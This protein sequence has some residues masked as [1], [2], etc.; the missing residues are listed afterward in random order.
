MISDT[1]GTGDVDVRLTFIEVR[2]AWHYKWRMKKD[3]NRMLCVYI[4]R[5]AS[6]VA[7]RMA[8]VTFVALLTIRASVV[9]RGSF[10]DSLDRTADV[11]V[12]I[13]I[14]VISVA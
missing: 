4:Y 12:Q 1:D 6:P 9:A 14:V 11:T 3:L 10:A 2:R 8:N 7:L 5:S 13:A